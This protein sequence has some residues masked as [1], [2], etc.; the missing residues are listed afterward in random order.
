MHHLSKV[1]L[2][3]ADVFL[4]QG[5][6]WSDFAIADMKLTPERVRLIPN[7]TATQEHLS[8]GQARVFSHE[9]KPRL[10]FVGWLEEFKGLTELLQ[11]VRVVRDEGYDFDLTLAGRG[12]AERSAKTFVE[13]N[14]LSERVHFAGWVEADDLR[15]LLDQHN[16]F[17]LPSWAEGLPNSMI[18][19]MAAGLAVVI[20]RVGMV[21]DFVIDGEHALLVP[22]KAPDLLAQALLRVVDDTALREKLA[23]NGYAL[24]SREFAVEPAVG[25]LANVIE[26]TL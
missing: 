22:T 21:P 11:A 5:K 2:K 6:S 23:R 12:D 20:T 17:V 4:S 7:W 16:I 18:E 9:E 8:I 1:A 13:E 15:T 25:K 3:G 24:A 26:A 10:I 19:A 14:C